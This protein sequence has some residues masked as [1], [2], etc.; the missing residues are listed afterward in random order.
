MLENFYTWN[1]L[2]IIATYLGYS[3]FFN[4][5]CGLKEHLGIPVFLSIMLS[6]LVIG[7]LLVHLQPIVVLL[8]LI[9][10]GLFTYYI[11][12]DR[13]LIRP[14]L[15]ALGIV[16]LIYYFRVAIGYY[17]YFDD[18]GLWAS[19]ARDVY[20]HD[21][22]PQPGQESLIYSHF[23][24]ARGASLFQ[25][26]HTKLLGIS[27][28]HNIFATGMLSLLCAS[29]SLS[30]K[31]LYLSAL[32]VAAIIAPSMLLSHNL[33]S[34]YLDAA[35]V[36]MFGAL[37]FFYLERR[38]Y[39]TTLLWSIPFLFVLPQIK[40]IGY[41]F[42]YGALFIF[43]CNVILF[44]KRDKVLMLIGIIILFSV[45]MLSDALW[46]GY[47]ANMGLIEHLKPKLGF[48]EFFNKL[49]Y[50]EASSQDGETIRAFFATFK[51]F[52]ILEGMVV[53]YV[54]VAFSFYLVSRY[55]P[56]KRNEMLVNYLLITL[57][58]A[59]YIL[60]RLSLYFTH[61]NT[62]EAI[63][64]A[65]NY[66]YLSTFAL[67]VPFIAVYYIKCAWE[68]DL[69]KHK[70]S[71]I[72]FVIMLVALSVITIANMKRPELQ[73]SPER[74]V[75]RKAARSIVEALREGRD[76]VPFIKKVHSFTGC[77]SLRQDLLEVKEYQ[78]IADLCV[79][80]QKDFIQYTAQAIKDNI[81]LGLNPLKLMTGIGYWGCQSLQYDLLKDNEE[82][83]KIAN[84]C[85]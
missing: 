10:I 31:S 70:L 2:I 60:F 59:V 78:K 39:R 85:R 4:N 46:K 45:P 65:S 5:K 51:R 71:K 57:C 81:K 11:I 44:N 62:V 75:A 15:W 23:Y 38:E 69:R 1:V 56:Q 84:K 74:A 35:V 37:L 21:N 54:L 13:E 28:G 49:F 55:L 18:L 26:F 53:I 48:V 36:F 72:L 7:A 58:F 27:E 14:E 73:L 76:P 82:Y 63:R 24:Y 16:I 29:V 50:Y 19:A 3:V 67:V 40:E 12:K 32:G 64:G 43:F 6:L 77:I 47:L 52:L 83:Q 33:R 79:V 34:L 20:L 41:W 22:L 30:R 68:T 61:F 8:Y 66:R 17:S 42:A 9:G 80:S 25:Y